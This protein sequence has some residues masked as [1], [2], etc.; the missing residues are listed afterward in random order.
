MP[1]SY[2]L[3]SNSNVNRSGRPDANLANDS[4]HL[5][6]IPAEDYATKEWVKDYHGSKESNLLDY[7]NRRDGEVLDEAKEYAN[8][9]VR[10]QDF[11]DFAGIDD[12]QALN[13]NLT[14]KINTDIA[15][16]KSYTDQKTQAIVEDVNSNFDDIEKAIGQINDGLNSS[17]NSLTSSINAVDDKV[18]DMNNEI[19]ELFQSVSSGKTIIAEAITD[20]GVSTSA[21]DS[22][23]TM[24][25]NIRKIDTLPSGDNNPLI[26]I[27][28]GY[29]DTSDATATS[30]KILQGYTAYA[31]GNKLYG[32]Y[33]P[34]GGGSTG[35]VILGPDE[36][37]ASKVY[38]EAGALIG[39]KVNNDG[40]T[41]NCQAVSKGFAFVHCSATFGGDFIIADRK[42]TENVDNEIVI[43]NITNAFLSHKSPSSKF[44][45]SYSELGIEGQ[46]LC[47]AASPLYDYDGIVQF[48]IGTTVGIYTYWFNPAGNDGNGSIGDA[49]P[50]STK[51]KMIIEEG[52]IS[53]DYNA[54]VYSNTDENV[55]AYYNGN[56]HIVC[57]A[58]SID[59]V[60][61]Y[62]NVNINFGNSN[63]YGMF[64]FS[65]SD[66][67]LMF[68]PWGDTHQSTVGIIL[69]DDMHSYK[70]HQIFT[71]N[72]DPTIGG[73]WKN[74][75][76]A[77]NPE[78]N[79]AIIN[80][81]P[82]SLT[83][84]LKN[85]TITWTKLSDTQLIPY[86]VNGNESL[87]AC[88]SKNG[89]YVFAVTSDNNVD[90]LFNLG[91]YKVDYENL[92][93][94]WLNVSNPLLVPGNANGAVPPRFNLLDNKVVGFYP[95]GKENNR[96]GFYYYRSDPNVREVIGLSWN[97]N[98]Y[99]EAVN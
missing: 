18:E 78:D 37:V 46:V 19:D 12:L 88:F 69:L 30:D 60:I 94:A 74:G 42:M 75:Q 91:C 29:M 15:N 53:N 63:V 31:N 98:L 86:N 39:Q 51:Q 61:E 84:S 8:T 41:L 96:D 28:E 71:D 27:P 73:S 57:I 3:I 89:K 4:E 2:E 79:F 67:F 7:I 21:N 66:R 95:S 6:G 14:N 1:K 43:Y 17:V 64:R 36:V 50:Y 72:Y 23:S 47:I 38:G 33:I 97:G 93:S 20:K 44:S 54:I 56:F 59:Q 92:N 70:V 90:G 82:Y 77:I 52:L 85:K 58:W 80:G 87:Y 11:S 48:S 16:Q 5:G 35:G 49:T 62:T 24:A 13:T 34:S 76:F 40:I 68:A 9:L 65:L 25:S 55:F 99:R 22:F 45:Y 10:N 32:T 26:V 83:Y 81:K